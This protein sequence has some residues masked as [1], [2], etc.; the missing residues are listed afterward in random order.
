MEKMKEKEKPAPVV[1]EPQS[2]KKARKKPVVNNYSEIY[3]FIQHKRKKSGAK[4]SNGNSL[5]FL[6]K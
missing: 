5:K 3:D 2:E 6:S 4:L 1:S